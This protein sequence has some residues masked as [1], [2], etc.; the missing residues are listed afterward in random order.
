[1][2]TIPLTPVRTAAPSLMRR[3]LKHARKYPSLWV[4]VAIMLVFVLMIL[5]ADIIAPTSPIAQEL[6]ERLKPPSAAHPFGTDE[7]GRDIYSRVIHGARISLPAS[8]FVVFVS[9]II[10]SLAGAAAGYFGGAVDTAV[11]RI[12]DVTLAFPS[13]VLALAIS[14]FL[15][16]SLTNAIIAASVVLWPEYARLMRSQVLVVRAYEYVTAARALGV[17]ESQI[18]FRHV[19]PNS[20]TPLIIKAALDVGGIILLVSALSFLGLGVSPP[21]PEWGSMIALGRTKFFQWWLATFPGIAIL[22]VILGCN[23]IGEGLRNWLDP[24]Y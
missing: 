2:T 16:P 21:T 9:V 3:V 6:T 10:G 23:L 20:W 5:F 22:L 14:A 1:M 19:L 12:A 15:G 11:M 13:V 18:L 4:G 7:L 8:F 17:P 24:N